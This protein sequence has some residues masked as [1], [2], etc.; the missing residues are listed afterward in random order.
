MTCYFINNFIY[1]C[2]CVLNKYV[3]SIDLL[4]TLCILINKFPIE[5]A[6]PT[7]TKGAGY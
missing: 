5:N 2:V 7:K 6:N 1:I 4:L 3:V